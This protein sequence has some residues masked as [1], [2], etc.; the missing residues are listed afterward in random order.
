MTKIKTKVE[1]AK[2]IKPAAKKI[3]MSL[4]TNK[5]TMDL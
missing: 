3:K 4:V 1:S 2:L 5:Q